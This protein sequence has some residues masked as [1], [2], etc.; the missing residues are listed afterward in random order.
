MYI[1]RSDVVNAPPTNFSAVNARSHAY[2]AHGYSYNKMDSASTTLT[3]MGYDVYV[4][5]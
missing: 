1:A 4:R 2:L 3:I 5:T